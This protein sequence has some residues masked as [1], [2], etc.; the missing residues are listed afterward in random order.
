MDV[1]FRIVARLRVLCNKVCRKERQQFPARGSSCR[2]FLPSPTLF[3]V[4]PYPPP[5][6]RPTLGWP[7]SIEFEATFR[8]LKLTRVE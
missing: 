5:P 2:S 4:A 1:G 8:W 7:H 6:A 3:V